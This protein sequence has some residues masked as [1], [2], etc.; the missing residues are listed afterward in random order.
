[1]Q[2]CLISISF[3]ASKKAQVCFLVFCK[4]RG[5]SGQHIGLSTYL[6]R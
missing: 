4:S 3:H 1:M 2:G 6:P 5:G